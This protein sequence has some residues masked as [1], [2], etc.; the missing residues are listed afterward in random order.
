MGEQFSDSPHALPNIPELSVSQLSQGL[1]K[2]VEDQFGH[3]RV[4]GELGRVS[5]PAS[6]HIYLDLKDDKAVLAGVV[7]RGVSSRLSIQPEEGME[8]IATGKL[9]TFPGQS[10]YQIVI[11]QIEVAGEGALM[12]LL[13]KRKKQFAGEGL[14]DAY[15]KKPLPFL[16]KVI[17][18]VTSP[19]GSVIRDILHRV[20]DRFGVHVIVWPVRVQGESCG[21]EVANGIAGLNAKHTEL[22]PKPDLI[23]VARGGGSVEDL[24]GFNEEAVVRA[25]YA[26]DIP[27]ISAV[28][29]ET[30]WTLVDLV[31]DV[32]APTPTG[33]AEIA[34]PVKSDLEAA[35]ADLNA[36]HQRAMMR[37][38]ETAHKSLLALSRNLG[39]VEHLL[40]I[41]RQ[42]FDNLAH[43]LTQALHMATQAK[44]ARYERI[45]AG[46]RWQILSRNL[47]L[48]FQK[49]QTLGNQ[50]D[51]AHAQTLKLANDKLNSL[52]RLLETLSHKSVLSRGFGYVLDESGK[53]ISKV[54]LLDG[55]HKVEL[56]MQDGSRWLTPQTSDTPGPKSDRKPRKPK[57]KSADHGQGDLF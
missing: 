53:M 14:F 22:F 39:S 57:A 56:H 17:G 51:R 8:V 16:P 41:P 20:S 15:H 46:M 42:M 32:R 40:A 37:N 23:I 43:R 1:R 13:E 54:A 12:A 55:A 36:R 38:L 3:V 9:T 7:W 49:L 18:V 50:L 26:S 44:R 47:E 31:A 19:T 28:G 10:K 33:A 24:W 11:D 27:V 5:R 21:Q 34:V 52:S 4:R 30:D 25:V 6:G 45:V 29:H 48:E 2:M 35:L